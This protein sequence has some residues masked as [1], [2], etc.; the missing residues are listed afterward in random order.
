MNERKGARCAVSRAP[1][2]ILAP[3]S[4]QRQT[5]WTLE[6]RKERPGNELVFFIHGLLSKS[7]GAD[8]KEKWLQL[9]P[10]SAGPAL[11]GLHP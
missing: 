6:E 7:G 4:K 8:A 9:G 11:H 3:Q 5:D 10:I 1:Y 2:H